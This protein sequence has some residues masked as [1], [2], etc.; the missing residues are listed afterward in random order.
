MPAAGNSVLLLLLLTCCGPAFSAGCISPL[1]C[2]AKLCNDCACVNGACVCSGGW[3]GA[4]CE[5]PFCHNRNDCSDHGDCR[6]E[7][8]SIVCMCDAGW[9]GARCEQFVCPLTCAH[10][11]LP[12]TNCTTCVNCLGAWTGSECAVWD[13][14]VPLDQLFGQLN[15]VILDAA[16]AQKDLEAVNPIRGNIGW[17]V[18]IVTGVLSSLPVVG[19]SYTDDQKTW[20]GYR[21]P[22]EAA[23]VPIENPQPV[24]DSQAFPLV[25]D[26]VAHVRNNVAQSGGQNGI[27]GNPFPSVLNGFYNRPGD[28]SLSVTQLMYAIYKI[29]LPSNQNTPYTLDKFARRALESLPPDYGSETNKALYR[30][31]L[32]TFG[33]SYTT[34]SD[35]GGLLE[36]HSVW[37]SWLATDPGYNAQT[38]AEQAAIDFGL[39]TGVCKQGGS[40]LPPY[41]ANRV[42]DGL[43][44]LGGS[45]DACA[46]LASWFLTV[47]SDP[48]PLSYTTNSISTLVSDPR[49][50]ASLEAAVAAWVQEK[51]S[52][53]A[54]TNL[55]PAQCAYGGSCAPGSATC[56]DCLPRASG[57]GCNHCGPAAS[58][59]L[60]SS[61]PSTNKSKVKEATSA[62]HVLRRCYD[63]SRG[64]YF[65]TTTTNC[66]GQP[67]YQKQMVLGGTNPAPGAPQL[68]RCK[69]RNTAFQQHVTQ[70]NQPCY[71]AGGDFQ[72][73]LILG[74]YYTAPGYSRRPMYRC[75]YTS[76][77]F[78]ST[79]PHCEGGAVEFLMGYLDDA[80]PD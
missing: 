68:I 65:T 1:E 77:S 57:R 23:V 39:T 10:G 51:N 70:A 45:P 74:G 34:S 29:E 24:C 37:Q 49:V 53:W 47:P 73:E 9:A 25:T 69:S 72:Q 20:H 32:E 26:Y 62:G 80:C 50:R 15:G 16:T 60:N 17:G 58:T 8:T 76:W 38:L 55:C 5:T 48:V 31:F 35:V 61:S 41:A 3:S 75:H 78:D 36:L 44:C 52:A 33:S 30:R 79:D 42:N 54:A 67:T 13:S 71:M 21:Y 19:L 40:M 63:P 4:A 66:E 7:M 22:V 6:M 43:T 56:G 12:D 59:F 14:N 28:P 64:D 11:G 2:N 46:V 27:Y 18:D